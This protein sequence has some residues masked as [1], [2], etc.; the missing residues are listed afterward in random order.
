[1]TDDNTPLTPRAL[2][3]V[4]RK[5]AQPPLPPDATPEER[6]LRQMLDDG[7]ARLSPRTLS[8][9]RSAIKPPAWDHATPSEPD[10]PVLP[11]LG[12]LNLILEPGLPDGYL[13]A[14]SPPP[15]PPDDRRDWKV[16]W[17]LVR[18]LGNL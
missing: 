6:A 12:G 15:D 17:W 10:R 2:A 16:R 14:V 11:L 7:K 18:D 1:M 4:V 3:E 5:L 8:D 13:F 9:L